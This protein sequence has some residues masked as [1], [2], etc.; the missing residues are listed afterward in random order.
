MIS[1]NIYGQRF[2]ER[3]EQ[4]PKYPEKT[5]LKREKFYEG[6]EDQ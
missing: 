1:T 2:A 3:M 4:K 5:K 6:L